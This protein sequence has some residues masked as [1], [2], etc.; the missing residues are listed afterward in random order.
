MK[1]WLRVLLTFLEAS[2]V[3]AVA[4]F[5]PSY[6][7]RGTLWREAWFDGKPTAYWRDELQ[8]WDVNKELG[9]GWLGYSHT[10]FTRTPSTIELWRARWLPAGAPAHDER[11]EEMMGNFL[12]STRGPKLLHGD[13]AAEPVLRELLDDPAPKIRLFAQ[14][15]LGM[16]PKI[17]GDDVLGGAP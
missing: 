11:W 1:P 6:H 9:F 14:F 8:H 3:L 7:V 15:G 4:Y 16:N 2:I 13:P 17:P 5:E 12:T 10:V